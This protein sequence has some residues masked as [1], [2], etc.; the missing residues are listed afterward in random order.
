MHIQV[1]NASTAGLVF[2]SLVV[3]DPHLETLG[4][5]VFQ[6]HLHS[7]CLNLQKHDKATP[8]NTVTTKASYKTQFVKGFPKIIGSRGR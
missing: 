5:A 3:C 7:P 6:N 8:N 2:V 1:A 4:L